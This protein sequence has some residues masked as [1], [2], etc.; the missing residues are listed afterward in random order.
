MPRLNKTQ[1]RQRA[2][3]LWK[4]ILEKLQ[5]EKYLSNSE[6]QVLDGNK[7]FE[8]LIFDCMTE[9]KK[10]EKLPEFVDNFE[11][12][13]KAIGRKHELSTFLLSVHGGLT[14]LLQEPG[15]LQMLAKILADEDIAN[16]KELKKRLAK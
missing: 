1:L 2:N 4:V 5:F 13:P 9:Y 7:Y 8:R 15:E 3:R 14:Y 12:D 6:T 11:F 10:K 16:C